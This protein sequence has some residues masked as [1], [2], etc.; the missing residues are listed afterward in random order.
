ML[1]LSVW[2]ALHH[3]VMQQGTNQKNKN[4]KVKV[5]LNVQLCSQEGEAKVF[6]CSQIEWYLI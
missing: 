3:A 4:E 5:E 1:Q 6:N 2:Q